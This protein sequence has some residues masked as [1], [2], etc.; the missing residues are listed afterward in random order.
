MTTQTQTLLATSPELFAA[1]QKEARR[2][3]QAHSLK[4]SLVT[5]PAT[6]LAVLIAANA[7]GPVYLDQG[8]LHFLATLLLTFPLALLLTLVIHEGGH[9]LA[10]AAAGMEFRLVTAGPFRLARELNGLRLRF[11]PQ[12][13]LQWQ[14]NAFCLLP[15]EAARQT[16]LRP[17][18]TLYLLG[19]PLATLGQTA[20]FFHLRA[21]FAGELLPAWQALLFFLLAY[22]PLATLP[23]TLLPLRL[24][25]AS[26]DAA[27]LHELWRDAAS[28]AEHIAANLLVAASTRGTRPRDLPQAHLE[29][30]LAAQNGA[31]TRQAGG[32]LASLKALDSGDAALAAR[33]LDGALTARQD[34]LPPPAYIMLA[35]W[36]EAREGGET[37]VAR[38]WLTLLPTFRH[39]AFAIELSQLLWQV[40]ATIHHAEGQ[41]PQAQAA[42]HHSLHL[43]NQ[44]LDAGQAIAAREQLQAIIDN[45]QLTINN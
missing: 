12:N 24:R 22:C 43:L 7:P 30:L 14:G 18:L 3:N 42:A 20:V 13:L 10:A 41:L 29:T 23:F 44:T 15:A 27:Q 5:I 31:E 32:Y 1:R 19:G 2:R 11:T 17:R 9:L 38:Q 21:Q 26:T 6:L 36:L 8:L 34:R 35:A 25:G 28:A 39:N 16:H 37:A 45:C 33:Y 4:T 40:K